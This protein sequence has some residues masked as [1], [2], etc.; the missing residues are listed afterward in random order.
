MDTSHIPQAPHGVDRRPARVLLGVAL[1][2][3]V[4][5]TAGA[6]A[7][8]F[9]DT[10]AALRGLVVALVVAA[11]SVGLGLVLCD[12]HVTGARAAHPEDLAERAWW[13]EAFGA[14]FLDLVIAMAIGLVAV[15]ISGVDLSTTGLLALLLAAG[16]LDATARYWRLQSAALA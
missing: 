10:D 5:A 3:A 13:G 14:S 8:A 6:F 16:L 7:A 4:A 11:P 2:V 15:A 12:A 1:G 9:A